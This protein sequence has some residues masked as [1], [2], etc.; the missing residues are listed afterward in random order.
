MRASGHSRLGLRHAQTLSNWA[1]K[2]YWP[3]IMLVFCDFRRHVGIEYRSDL[4]DLA[5]SVRRIA[6]PLW[7]LLL[8]RGVLPEPGFLAMTEVPWT[9]TT[10]SPCIPR[11][12]KSDS[13]I[14]GGSRDVAEANRG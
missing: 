1:A 5:T 9:A 4:S 3:A 2:A 8:P 10:S 7:R 6:K 11:P 14:R 12:S 13:Q